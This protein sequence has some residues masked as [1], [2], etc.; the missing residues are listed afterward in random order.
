MVKRR[1]LLNRQISKAMNQ[2]L[3]TKRI[4]D[5]LRAEVYAAVLD[6]VSDKAGFL[7]QVVLNATLRDPLL[8][9]DETCNI[10]KTLV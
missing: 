3:L 1:L 8:Y 2:A 10:V 9:S 4:T 7:E 6:A 5:A